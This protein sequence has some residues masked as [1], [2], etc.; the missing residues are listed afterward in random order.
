MY[1]PRLH[2][3]ECTFHKPDRAAV[4]TYT[5]LKTEEVL[6]AS[7]EWE[8]QPGDG[9][10]YPALVWN[11]HGLS[12]D[13]RP[14]LFYS[15]HDP[16]A[17]IALAIADT[18]QDPSV[19]FNRPDAGMS[20]DSRVLHAPV[21]PRQTSHFSSPSVVWDATTQQWRIYFHFY[22]NAYAQGC[23]HQKTAVA[24]AP[25][26]ETTQWSIHSDG[27]AGYVAVLPIQPPWANSQ[28][29]YHAIA[30]LGPNLWLA[31]LRGTQITQDVDGTIAAHSTSLALATSR[32]GLS[33]SLVPE[34]PFA[35]ALAGDGVLSPMHILCDTDGTVSIMYQ[36]RLSTTSHVYLAPLE[37]PNHKERIFEDPVFYDGPISIVPQPQGLQIF[38]GHQVYLIQV[39]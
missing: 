39:P 20:P 29:S 36:R 17:G 19:K 25:E 24:T 6:V 31:L 15:V 13:R 28:S 22:A 1:R 26:L 38:T 4:R 9:P 14:F 34:A 2:T 11:D 16:E 23:G 10:G 18:A 33:W 8:S 3:F 37:A 7:Q 12:A 27:A 30:R 35:Q 5:R 21:R 32:D